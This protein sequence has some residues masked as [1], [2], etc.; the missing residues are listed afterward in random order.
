MTKPS[1]VTTCTIVGQ[2]ISQDPV[3]VTQFT[4]NEV[5]LWRGGQHW[6][7]TDALLAHILL[8]TFTMDY[9]TKNV[10]NYDVSNY[11]ELFKEYVNENTT[12]VAIDMKNLKLPVLGVQKVIMVRTYSA[13]FEFTR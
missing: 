3:N 7:N 12:K 4:N 13:F 8:V 10:Q 6:R 2:V 11:N 9:Q 5:G 1:I